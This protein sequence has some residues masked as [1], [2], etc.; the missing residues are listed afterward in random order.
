MTLHDTYTATCDGHRM[1][2]IQ[3]S[4]AYLLFVALVFEPMPLASIK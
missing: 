2:L 3:L 4:V 1:G